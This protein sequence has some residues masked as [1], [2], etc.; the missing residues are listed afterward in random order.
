MS[1]ESHATYLYKPTPWD[2]T[3]LESLHRMMLF[4]F[5]S[6]AAFGLDLC[7]FLYESFSHK[8]LLF[9]TAVIIGFL[10]PFMWFFWMVIRLPFCDQLR[11]DEVRR[12]SP[13]SW[14][15][16]PRSRGYSLRIDVIFMN[17]VVSFM[18]RMWRLSTSATANRMEGLS[19]N[20]EFNNTLARFTSKLCFSVRS[21]S[22]PTARSFPSYVF[23]EC[24]QKDIKGGSLTDDPVEIS[25]QKYLGVLY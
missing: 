16:G 9:L 3:F 5:S 12:L 8:A 24:I 20:W 11:V 22:Y 17:E 1:H 14:S 4:G 2:G 6:A 23:F 19:C 15:V 13:K 10:S 25:L 18:S 21:R 7:L